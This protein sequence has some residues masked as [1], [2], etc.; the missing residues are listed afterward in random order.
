MPEYVGRVRFRNRIDA[1]Q[2]LAERLETLGLADPIVLGLPRGGIPVAWV[3]AKRLGAPLDVFVARK[4]GAPGHQELGIG[5]VAEGC[6]EV[7]VTDN[8]TNLGLDQSLMPELVART[9]ADVQVRVDAYRGTR[10]LPHL[11][12]RDVIVVDD[13]L[14][15]GV[16]AEVAL[17]ALRHQEPAQLILGAPVGARD[18]ID[19]LAHLA[20]QVVCLY[21]PVV[22]YAVGEWYEDFSQTT[23]AEVH[24]MLPPRSP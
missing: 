24:R 10:A 8:A 12:G 7:V 23:D 2:Q 6:D 15:T 20:D 19:R 16:T 22:F 14:A 11:G 21:A 17:R 3:V 9:R 5:A 13:G 18:A 4:V 1:G